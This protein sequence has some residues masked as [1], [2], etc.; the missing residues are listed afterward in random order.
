MSSDC[1][2]V[3]K[4][5]IFVCN[6][7]DYKGNFWKNL[8]KHKLLNHEQTLLKLDKKKDFLF[9]CSHCDYANNRKFYFVQHCR[10]HHDFVPDLPKLVKHPTK[11]VP[12]KKCDFV[13]S[14]VNSLNNHMK[15]H[16]SQ[17]KPVKCE[18]CEF[19][20]TKDIFLKRHMVKHEV[21][22]VPLH[23][24][25]HCQ[26]ILANRDSL[27]SHIRSMHTK[28][29]ELKCPQC[30]YTT[31]RTAH[32][33]NHIVKAHET[34][35]VFYKCEKCGEDFKLKSLLNKHDKTEH[36]VVDEKTY[37]FECD[38]C[39]YKVNTFNS[40]NKH[41]RARHQQSLLNDD[42][43]HVYNCS[44]C[45]YTANRVSNFEK[46]LKSSHDTVLLKEDF[47][48]GDGFKCQECNKMFPNFGTLYKHVKT[49]HEN[50]DMPSKDSKPSTSQKVQEE[51]YLFECDKCDYKANTF[52]TFNE[53]KRRQHQQSLL[54]NDYKHGYNCSQ[55]DYTSNRLS[56]FEKH[57]KSKHDT[58]LPK[59]DFQSSEGFKC[60][61][62]KRVYPNFA[63][64]YKHIKNKH[65]HVDIP[66]VTSD[67]TI[68]INESDFSSIP[69]SYEMPP[70]KVEP[71]DDQDE[72]NQSEYY[73]PPEDSFVLTIKEEPVAIVDDSDP[74]T[75]VSD[76]TNDETNMEMQ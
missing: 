56:L 13:G 70:V 7:C 20:T 25:P 41:N 55:C 2:S 74:Q 58:T 6:E 9:N 29:G 45:D 26:K 59:E 49:K 3:L 31:C 35:Q 48:S 62:C 30:D 24:C 43:K 33:K 52:T 14:T 66:L 34:P 50:G 46:H 75:L 18:L 64:L 69:E 76:N 63:M 71:T 17:I 5:D 67:T 65:E 60:R 68:G 53:H 38:K 12:C 37:L 39:D 1:L 21:K 57:L 19:R 10:N 47:K 28:E 51:N 72:D 15:V 54:N 40:F 16:Q 4:F 23:I 11:P 8:R 73:V 22:E 61:D 42:Y 44:K 36:K 32:L 27:K